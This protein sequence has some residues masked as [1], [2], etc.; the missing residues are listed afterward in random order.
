MVLKYVP[1]DRILSKLYRDL[2]ILDINE[3]DVI[4]WCGEALDHIGVIT[5]YEK[6]ISIANV[7]NHTAP[8][9]LGLQAIEMVAVNTG[10]RLDPEFVLKALHGSEVLPNQEGSDASN[11]TLK[12]QE[13]H[14]NIFEPYINIPVEGY[15]NICNKFVALRLANHSLFG[16]LVLHEKEGIIFN[17][18]E[19]SVVDNVLRFSFKEGQI[20]ISH[21]RQ[22][23]DEKNGYPLIPDVTAV[24]QAVTSYV[25]YKYMQR[26]WYSGRQG[27]GDKMR[28]AEQDWQW[29]CRQA[30]GVM[31][32]PK[33]VQ[34][35]QDLLHI[36]HSKLPNHNRYY[37]FFGNL[38]RR[39]K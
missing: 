13:T 32:M 3:I 2:G 10:E 36:Q 30:K 37:G 15:A 19:Y 28:I 21:Y 22:P 20:L 5:M 11:D 12:S 35:H 34:E 1:L 23:L 38:A 9:P 24:I 18:D 31:V 8:L 16:S 27:F 17:G 39:D 4:E 14:R 6:I 33:G 25:T 26:N 29:Y 7:S